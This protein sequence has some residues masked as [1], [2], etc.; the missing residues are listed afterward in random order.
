VTLVV[1]LALPGGGVW[2]G[3]DRIAGGDTPLAGPKVFRTD[4]PCCDDFPSGCDCPE[5]VVGSALLAFAGN[6]RVAQV[7]CRTW[8]PV[9]GSGT[10][11]DWW[12]RY[13]DVL[14]D[15][16]ADAHLLVD[17]PDRED[18]VMT[19]GRSDVLVATE[20]RVAKFD[21]TLAWQESARG[22]AAT[23]A[24]D[25]VWEGAYLALLRE[26]GLERHVDT[27]ERFVDAARDAW[28]AAVELVAVGPLVDELELP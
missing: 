22:Y 21:P 5:E 18:G 17:A 9:R 15:A 20:G 2:V 4:V 19:A 13:A 7:A 8:P 11:D 25:E 14:H 28:T 24:A 10:L 27:A 26:R 16:Y 23:G 3:G 12:T 6:A 1:A